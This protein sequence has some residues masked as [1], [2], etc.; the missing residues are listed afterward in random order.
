MLPAKLLGVADLGE[1]MHTCA[2]RSTHRA[3]G[4]FSSGIA[5]S[6]AFV[7]SAQGSIVYQ[8]APKPASYV[9]GG[10]GSSIEP[11]NNDRVA[12]GF[13]LDTAATVNAV[14]FWGMY[15]WPGY[16][17][18]VGYRITVWNADGVAGDSTGLDLTGAPGS[19]L[20]NHDFPVGDSSLSITPFSGGFGLVGSDQFEATLPEALNLSSNTR[21]WISIA[22]IFN[23]AHQPGWAWWD[24]VESQ[25][26]GAVYNI[27]IY[28]Q[29]WTYGTPGSGAQSFA[30]LSVPAPGVG[31]PC[32]IAALAATTRRRRT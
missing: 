4:I 26:L 7:A 1:H 29:W 32:V 21:Y 2:L 14:R 13:S 23:V 27:F 28:D 15:N 8:Q 25:N 11:G 12:A 19:V 20:Y 3:A 5:I 22:G 9:G 24:A 30:L 16:V 31:V 17:P 18:P 10:A 6:F